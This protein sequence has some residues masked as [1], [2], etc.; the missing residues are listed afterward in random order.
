MHNILI[1]GAN[2]Q[3]T[4]PLRLDQEVRDIE[5][6]LLRSKNRDGFKISQKWAVRPRDVRRAMLDVSPQIVHFSG[7][8][9]GEQG[10]VFED[11]VGQPQLIRGEALASLFKLFSDQLECVVLNGCYS[12]HQANEICK[13]ID[14]VV[15]MQQSLGD[16]AAIEFAVGFYDAL[17]AGRSVEFAYELGCSAIQLSGTVGENVPVLKRKVSSL[18]SVDTD[19]IE[20]SKSKEDGSKSSQGTVEIFFSYSH[21]DEELRDELAI[22]LKMLQRQGIISSWHDRE[23]SAGMEWADQIDQHM[24]KSQVILLLIS[25]NFLASDYCYD[26]EL[27]RA[28]ERHDSGEATVIPIIL[29]PTDWESASFGKLQALPKNAKPITLWENR[30]LAFLDVAKGIRHIVEKM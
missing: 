21:E 28:M 16:K 17:G 18:E 23:I 4:D 1:L 14:Y 19:I 26:I 29:K 3:Q 11:E 22:H 6:G 25:A 13:H 24:E 15:G 20:N 9:T 2:P 27:K 12:E 7:H 10:L 30:D 8:G 5:E